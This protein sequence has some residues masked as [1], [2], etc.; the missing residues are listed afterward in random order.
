[1]KRVLS[2]VGGLIG[3]VFVLGGAAIVTKKPAMKPA[4]SEKIQATPERLARGTYL[5]LHVSSCPECHS[6]HDY[7]KFANPIK[8]ETLN[9]GGF[10]LTEKDGFPGSVCTSNISPDATGISGWTDGELIRAIR[11]GVDKDGRALFPMM[12]YGQYRHMSDEDVKSLVVWLR[13]QKPVHH[14]VPAT[15]LKFP[16]SFFIKM[17]PKPVEGTVTAPP[18]SA[19]LEY[20]KYMVE[21]A[22]CVDCHTP[23]NKGRPIEG[24]DFAGGREFKLPD[25]ARVVSANIT[26]DETGIGPMTKEA[27]VGR[28]RS[29][30]AM[31]ELPAAE[32]GHNTIM[33]W[34]LYGGMDEDDLG[35]IYD[36]LR[37][38]KPVQ[39]AVNR[40]PDGT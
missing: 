11:E 34:L 15:N 30:A 32:K 20:G 38:L 36:Y 16:V 25:G 37:T 28:F 33:P 21:I 40:F 10:C 2:I 6:D 22:G 29:Y 18:K 14:E 12:P 13:A 35:A 19:H 4:S 17:A 9:G 39:H 8:A 24:M 5:A 3:L 26:P 7:S 31:T 1:M 23:D 27:F